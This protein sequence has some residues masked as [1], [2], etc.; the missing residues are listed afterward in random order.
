MRRPRVKTTGRIIIAAVM[1]MA[2]ATARAVPFHFDFDLGATRYFSYSQYQIGERIVNPDGTVSYAAS[3]LSELVFPLDMFAGYANLNVEIADRFIIRGR[4]NMSL[5]ESIYTGKMEDSDWNTT[6]LK[7]IY[8]ESGAYSV[9]FISSDSVIAY[10]LFRIS[11]FSLSMGIGFTYQYIDFDIKDLVQGDILSGLPPDFTAVSGLVLTYDISY[12]LPYIV[13]YPQF[14]IGQSIDCL[15]KV[16][17]SP[18]AI[19][20]DHDDH[21][22]RAKLSEG[23]ATGI[24]AMVAVSFRWRFM[25]RLFLTGECGVNAVFLEGEQRQVRYATT[26]EGPPGP[27]GTINNKIESVQVSLSLGVG[28]YLDI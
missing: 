24:A 14:S 10:R 21:V 11:F 23:E 16:A 8:S 4:I 20:R 25:W 22:L 5:S 2:G 26:L 3:P 12:Y 27:I 6:G 17:I 1:V 9:K 7:V 19:G 13:L 15:L 28:M 18:Y